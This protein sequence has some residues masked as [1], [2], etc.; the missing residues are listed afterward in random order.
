MEW[1]KY[2]VP[3][4]CVVLGALL[5]ALFVP[6]IERTRSKT[7]D[8]MAAEKALAGFYTEMNDVQE[9]AKRYIENLHHAYCQTVKLKHELIARSEDFYPIFMPGTIKLLTYD[10]VIEK[11]F[12]AAPENVRRA[13]RALSP[14]V[15][16]VNQRSAL[17]HSISDKEEFN[18]HDLKSL[19]GQIA[20]LYYISNRLSLEQGR[21]T[22][23]DDTDEQIKIN[24]FSALSLAFD[25]TTALSKA[26]E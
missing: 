11:A 14:I 23:F 26:A 1:M 2:A 21:F 6:W 20:I 24:V 7:V 8:K 22:Y 13:I 3:V 10:W 18:E 12:A 5:G 4:F 9:S 19:A 17:L 15:D 16:A 25:E